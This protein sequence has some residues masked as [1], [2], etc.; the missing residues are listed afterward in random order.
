MTTLGHVLERFQNMLGP[1]VPLLIEESWE[2]SSE[3]YI[4][5]IEHPL[6]RIWTKAP[7]E[8]Q[9]IR[10][11]RQLP[12]IMAVNSAVKAGQERARSE[13][14][15]GQSLASEVKLYLR[16][17]GIDWM[18]TEAWQDILVVSKVEVLD[19]KDL[20]QGAEASN[21]HAEQ[22]WTQSIDITACEGQILGTTVVS[23]PRL[24]KCS[25][26]WKYTVHSAPEE[27]IPLCS[28]CEAVVKEF[29]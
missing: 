4:K 2:H 8:W 19:A 12:I 18:S 13:K 23:G 3:E 5:T 9:D 29:Q 20:D 10:I 26:C 1:V 21:Q 22:S 17:P 25:R 24:G 28:R 14:L 27:T 6:K 15:L 7:P 16:E 11:Q